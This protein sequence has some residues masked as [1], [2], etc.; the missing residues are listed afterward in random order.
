[1]RLRPSLFTLSIGATL[2]A[3]AV[4][5]GACLLLF[6]AGPHPAPVE[7]VGGEWVGLFAGGPVEDPNY[8]DPRIAFSEEKGSRLILA[9]RGKGVKRGKGVT[10]HSR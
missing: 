10:S 4:Y 8:L 6:A 9:E 5:A 7:T 1:M 3:L 2:L